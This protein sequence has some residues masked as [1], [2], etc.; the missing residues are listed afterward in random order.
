MNHKA[1]T[2]VTNQKNSV[3]NPIIWSDIPD[4]SVI[5]VG[6]TF[7]MSSTTMHMNPGIPIMKSMDLVNWKIVNYVYDTLE[8]NDKQLLRNGQ[9]EYSKGSWASSLRYHNDVF[10]L[11]VASFSAGKTYIFQTRDIENGQW[12]RST[13]DGVYHD[14][15]LLFDNG[16]VYMVYGG[17]DIRLIE[18]TQDATTIKEGGL[19]KIIIPN[20]SD[21]IGSKIKLPAEGAHIHKINGKYYIFLITW[22]EN[23]IRTQLV[24]RSDKIDGDYEGKVVVSDAGIA[25]GGVVDTSDGDWYALLFGDR[26]AVGR[27]P[28]LVPITWE[29]DWPV[30]GDN[31]N[32]PRKIPIPIQ[33]LN[34][35]EKII[36]SDEFT[37]NSEMPNAGLS[38]VWQWNH[39]PDNKHWSLTDRPGYLRLINGSKSTNIFDARNTLTQRTYGPKCSGNIS[40]DVTQMKDGDVAGL[41]AFQECY[42]FVGVKKDGNSKFIV[43]EKGSSKASE[44]LERIPINQ[45]TVYLKIAFDFKQ[46]TDKAYFFYSLDGVHWKTIGDTLQMEYTI[47]H[48]MGYRFALLNYATKVTKGYVDFDY[49]RVCVTN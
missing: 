49:F 34:E 19:D 33:G 15:S 25:Q 36:A 7:Y 37:M 22:P 47:P 43:M 3:N 4:P 42:G 8:D 27:I 6:D 2:T 44:E 14:M 20:S 11:A 30:Y 9:S 18:L 48:F 26:G 10:Y 21:I 1:N 40:M 28:Y 16:R 23:G 31:G 38:L 39:N 29:D 46:Q 24:Y 12:T 35:K 5:R 45:D 32:I 13:I 41:A 17:G